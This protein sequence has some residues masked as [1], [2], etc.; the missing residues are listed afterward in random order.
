MSRQTKLLTKLTAVPTPRDFT[1]DEAC[2]LM[3]HC[4]FEKTNGKGSARLF[5]HPT[6][7]QKVRLHE[8][9]PAKTLKPYMVKI[10][11][12]AL[13]DAGVLSE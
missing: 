1:W 3:K 10:L 12:D 7:K 6:T 2:T 11:I 5:S 9:H 4:G 13:K 8:P